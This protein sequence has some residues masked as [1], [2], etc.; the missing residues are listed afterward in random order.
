LI[1]A[2]MIVVAGEFGVHTQRFLHCSMMDQG[3]HCVW[4]EEHPLG[5]GSLQHGAQ[6][7]EE[8]EEAVSAAR[9]RI[10]TDRANWNTVASLS[11]SV[12]FNLCAAWSKLSILSGWAI[13]AAAK[14]SLL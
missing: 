3:L 6:D 9:I 10:E 5:W 11:K 14:M 2:A 8:R 1:Q 12:P 13:L 7:A 4:L